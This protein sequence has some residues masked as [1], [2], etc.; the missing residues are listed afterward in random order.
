MHSLMNYIVLSII[1]MITRQTPLN[2]NQQFINSFLGT[3][4]MFGDT[5]FTVIEMPRLQGSKRPFNEHVSMSASDYNSRVESVAI[6]RTKSPYFYGAPDLQTR[7]HYGATTRELDDIDAA[8]IRKTALL[9]CDAD[10]P[11][12]SADPSNV[13]VVRTNKYMSFRGSPLLQR[14][15]TEADAFKNAGAI[16]GLFNASMRHDE[17]RNTVKIEYGYHP[18]NAASHRPCLMGSDI[19]PITRTRDMPPELLRS[20]GNISALLTGGVEEALRLQHNDRK[21]SLFPNNHILDMYRARLAQSMGVDEDLIPILKALGISVVIST[22]AFPC[23]YHHGTSKCRIKECHGPLAGRSIGPLRTLVAKADKKRKSTSTPHNIPTLGPHV[24]VL[25]GH[26]PLMLFSFPIDPSELTEE[27][28]LFLEAHGQ[29]KYELLWM[30]FIAYPRRSMEEIAETR[31]AGEKKM[32]NATRFIVNELRHNDADYEAL[33]T[34]P[35]R[36]DRLLAQKLMPHPR[37]EGYVVTTQTMFHPS[38]YT[39]SMV[40]RMLNVSL[41]Y[42]LSTDMIV[43]LA[44]VVCTLNG[45]DHANILL[46]ELCSGTI[47]GQ[48]VEYL[49]ETRASFFQVAAIFIRKDPR[50]G[51][52]FKKSF[53]AWCTKTSMWPRCQWHAHVMYSGESFYQRTDS[54]DEMIHITKTVTVK[55]PET[56]LSKKVKKVFS[57]DYIE[58]LDILKKTVYRCRDVAFKASEKDCFEAVSELYKSLRGRANQLGPFGIQKFVYLLASLVVIPGN[59]ATFAVPDGDGVVDFLHHDNHWPNKPAK[60]SW[61][62]LRTELVSVGAMRD[63]EMDSVFEPVPCEGLRRLKN[64]SVQ[65]VIFVEKDHGFRDFRPNNQFIFKRRKGFD[66]GSGTP[67]REWVPCVQVW[68][69]TEKCGEKIL[70]SSWERVDSVYVGYALSPDASPSDSVRTRWEYDDNNKRPSWYPENEVGFPKLGRPIILPE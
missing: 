12:D 6:P 20:V 11:Y 55:D 58:E 70:L 46:R 16:Q 48:S 4:P 68:R 14:I 41:K 9:S 1:P 51:A 54:N 56:G 52:E 26:G 30:I 42:K 21:L 53:G 62:Q 59:C 15:V 3:N 32:S 2:H 8:L 69:E 25:N 17:K 67:T 43:E 60:Q 50:F 61:E 57:Y 13:F 24:D 37:E 36:F 45:Q 35:Y 34:N 5:F 49:V 63:G 18:Q 29:P 40:C 47:M 28:Q 31:L 23:K 33:V 66:R 27:D 19:Y 38:P 22:S 10:T 7:L 65:D 44:Y 39:N 64:K